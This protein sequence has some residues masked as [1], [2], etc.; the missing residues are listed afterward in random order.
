MVQ[1]LALKLVWELS[2]GLGL[3]M[4]FEVELL[5]MSEWE[6]KSHFGSVSL[7][8]VEWLQEWVLDVVA[9]SET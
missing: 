9:S 7:K 4:M 6:P 1:R 8:V 3:A 2:R 5:L